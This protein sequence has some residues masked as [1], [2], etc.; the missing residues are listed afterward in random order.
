MRRFIYTKVKR[1][2]EDRNKT[3]MHINIF[4]IGEK[5]FLINYNIITRGT[6]TI[7]KKWT[8]KT[9]DYVII[10]VHTLTVVQLAVGYYR[11]GL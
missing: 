9:T 6:N 4:N 10:H 7:K 1:V 3:L 11:K 2:C 5:H 8:D